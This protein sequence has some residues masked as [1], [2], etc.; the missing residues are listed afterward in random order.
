MTSK[1]TGSL[2]IYADMEVQIVSKDKDEQYPS[3]DIETIFHN[4]HGTLDFGNIDLS[5]AYYQTKLHENGN[6]TCIIAT[7]QG[8]FRISR[9][10]QCLTKSSPVVKNSIGSIL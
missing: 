4:L 3:T 2:R 6:E 8:L 7:S 10:P 1:E 9:L 5:D